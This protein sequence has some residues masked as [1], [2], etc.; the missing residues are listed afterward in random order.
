[1][2]TFK[3]RLH[4]SHLGFKVQYYD[5]ETGL[6]YNRFRYYD[7]DIGRFISQD[8]IG[9]MGGVNLYQY[10]PNPVGWVDPLGL[11][12]DRMIFVDTNKVNFSQGYVEDSKYIQKMVDDIKSGDFDLKKHPLNVQIINGQMVSGD[13]R[14]LVAAKLTG[15]TVP[16]IIRDAN[17]KMP[18]GGTYGKN[19]T[20]KL[21]SAP[22]KNGGNLKKIDVGPTGTSQMPLVVDGPNGNKTVTGRAD[23]GKTIICPI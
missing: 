13:N 8:P 23:D 10:A 15:Q 7:P 11:S 3:K 18:T 2:L 4:F 5:A 17:E 12:G 16:I 14:R 6:H 9:L 21:N 22:K 1:M 20:N 19:L